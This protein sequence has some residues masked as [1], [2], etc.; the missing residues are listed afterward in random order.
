MAILAGQNGINNSR[1]Y[2]RKYKFYIRENQMK[3]IRYIFLTL[4]AATFV[5]AC[6]DELNP[7]DINKG[8]SGDEVQF[9]AALPGGTKTIYG[10]ETA[11]GFPIYW[12]NGDKV[13]VA[14]PQCL[15]GRNYAEYKVSVENEKQNYAT[16]LTKTGDYGVQWG[17]GETAD[18][19]SIYPSEACEMVID[20]NSVSATL[21]VD[22][23]QFAN[24]VVSESSYY[25]QPAKMGNVIMYAK[26]AGVESGE[27][28]NLTYKPFSTVIEFELDLSTTGS[29]P[30]TGIIVQS[31]TL[32]APTDKIIAGKFGFKFGDTPVV[33]PKADG[34]NNS[35]TLHFLDNDQYKIT[36]TQSKPTLKAKMCLIPISDV[37]DLKGWK[38][39]VT[40]SAGKFTKTLTDQTGELKAGLVHKIKLPALSS[41]GSG[42]DNSNWISSLPDY[43]NIYLTELSLPGAWYAGSTED[44]QATSD[45]ATLWNAGVRAFAVESKTITGGRYDAVPEGVVLSGTGT[46]SASYLKYSSGT[47]SLHTTAGEVGRVYYNGTSISTIITNIA[48]QVKKDEYAVLVLSYADGGVSGMRYV[49]YGAWLNL[50]YNVFS[51]LNASVKGKIYQGEITAN[52]TVNDVLG[53]LILKINIDANIA[54][55]GTVNSRTFTYGN[56]LPALFSYNPFLFQMSG[57]EKYSVPFFSNLS[58]STWGD[59]TDT[60]RKYMSAEEVQTLINPYVWCFSSAN[61][62]QV[63]SGTDGTIPTYAN[64][65]AALGA[66]MRYS[67]QIYDASTHNVWF[68]F[69]C[70]GTEATSQTSDSPSPSPAK[71]AS[72]MNPWLLERIQIK[73]G[74]KADPETG[75]TSHDPSPLGIVMFNQCTNTAYSGPAIIDAIIR[76]NSM[77]Y[78]KHAGTSGGSTGGSTGGSGSETA[79]NDVLVNN[80]GDAI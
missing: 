76:M 54:M 4:A 71:F 51:R 79:Q 65:K 53:K 23:T 73:S 75:L 35:I 61:R 10:D 25:S 22:A 13:K 40:T 39:E 5:T 14:S 69:N 59:D 64:R 20:G 2:E 31:I 24:T 70:G 3:T 80:G 36:L 26:T 45:I 67:K 72:K 6:N 18:F 77:F 56:N 44:Y 15:S 58:W 21:T 28:V 27:A 66:M 46:N 32:T 34:G 55:S 7:N 78:L 57:S 38:V 48:N 29:V 52:T 41:S 16:E 60:H 49:D 74:D 17:S 19:Y 8:N 9:G 12:V 62:T 33:T 30:E 47:N 50:L 42:Y 43:G 68:Y 1:P 63:D 11:T 37:R